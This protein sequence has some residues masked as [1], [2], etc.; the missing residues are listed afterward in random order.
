MNNG[1]HLGEAIDISSKVQPSVIEVIP[2]DDQMV[3]MKLKH[4]LDF[5]SFI[6]ELYETEEKVFYIHLY[7]ILD[8]CSCRDTQCLG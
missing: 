1:I 7:S 3:Q 5:S 4:T 8:Q 2:F 6:T